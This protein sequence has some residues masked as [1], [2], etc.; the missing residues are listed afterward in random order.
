MRARKS[1]DTT[2]V[3]DQGFS[4]KSL[5]NINANPQCH[6]LTIIVPFSVF[7]FFL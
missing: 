2:P 6:C 1:F 4:P 7:H 3:K 5:P